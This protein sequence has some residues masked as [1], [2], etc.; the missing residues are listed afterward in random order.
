M[1][2]IV[3]ALGA[4]AIAGTVAAGGSAFTAGG[5]NK[6]SIAS[7]TIVL[8]NFWIE[9]HLQL[10]YREIFVLIWRKAYPI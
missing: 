3:K 4:L 1:K 6:D 8:F 9:V 7:I 2:T 5:V 10:G